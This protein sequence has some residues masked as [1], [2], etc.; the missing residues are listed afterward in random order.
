MVGVFGSSALA[1]RFGLAELPANARWLHMLGISLLCGIGFTMSLFIGLLAFAGDPALQ[2]AVKVGILAG[3]A[4]CR[5]A[6]RRRAAD[7][8]GGRRRGR[9]PGLITQGTKGSGGRPKA[10]NKAGPSGGT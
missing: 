2:D 4:G 7:G 10:A 8:A 1:I 9:G 6:G 5:A 3:L